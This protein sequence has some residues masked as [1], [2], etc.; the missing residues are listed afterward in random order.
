LRIRLRLRGY[1]VTRKKKPE[2][3]NLKP[4]GLLRH[5]STEEGNSGG[6]IAEDDPPPR[7][8]RDKVASEKG[9]G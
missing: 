2:T 9:E 8:R 4:G 6:L 3:G 5:G 1:G 7:L